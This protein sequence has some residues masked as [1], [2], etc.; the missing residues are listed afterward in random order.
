MVLFY[1]CLKINNKDEIIQSF[2]VLAKETALD[3]R[4]FPAAVNQTIETEP[5]ICTR[6]AYDR[7]TSYI[8][9]TFGNWKL[10]YIKLGSGMAARV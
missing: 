7:Y 8:I 5:V 10:G 4:L 2:L 9:Q 1:L 3:L 6:L